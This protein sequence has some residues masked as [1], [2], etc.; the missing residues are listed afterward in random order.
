MR[1]LSFFCCIIAVQSHCKYIRIIGLGKTTTY[2]YKNTRDNSID[3]YA[4]KN[5]LLTHQTDKDSCLWRSTDLTKPYNTYTNK[6][7]DVDVDTGLSNWVYESGDIYN[8]YTY[9]NAS[10]ECVDDQ[11]LAVQSEFFAALAIFFIV[12][13]VIIC[14]SF[15]THKNEGN[16]GG[17]ENFDSDEE[18][19]HSIS[20]S[21]M[22]TPL[23]TPRSSLDTPVFPEV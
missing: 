15:C 17:Q 18:D 19:G 22:P 12:F 16:E 3:L 1:I 21:C 10:I 20:N 2:T 9:L 5:K 23:P 8:T 7:C 6:D 14:I 4:S 11:Y 13:W